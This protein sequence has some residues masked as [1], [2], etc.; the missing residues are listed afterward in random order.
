MACHDGVWRTYPL[1]RWVT[2]MYGQ[3]SILFKQQLGTRFSSSKIQVLAGVLFLLAQRKMISS[4]FWSRIPWRF[5][6]W[7]HS[8]VTNFA[9]LTLF[10][11]RLFVCL[12]VCLCLCFGF[13]SPPLLHPTCFQYV[14]SIDDLINMRRFAWPIMCL[15]CLLLWLGVNAGGDSRGSQSDGAPPHPWMGGCQ[16]FER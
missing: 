1:N 12:F 13:I 15:F 14:F 3:V 5:A 6:L 9:M 8:M 4:F 2:A 10:F 7:K 11:C 16:Q